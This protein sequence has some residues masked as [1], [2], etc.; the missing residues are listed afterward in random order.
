MKFLEGW[1]ISLTPT[2]QF[3]CWSRSQY[4]SRKFYHFSIVVPIARILQDWWRFVLSICS[5]VWGL[6][7]ETCGTIA[8]FVYTVKTNAYSAAWCCE[9][10]TSVLG[11]PL[12]TSRAKPFSDFAFDCTSKPTWNSFVSRLVSCAN[13]MHDKYHCNTAYECTM[14]HIHT[15][16]HLRPTASHAVQNKETLQ[17]VTLLRWS[18]HTLDN[19]FAILRSVL[20]MT[21]CPETI[22]HG[23]WM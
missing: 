16:L 12:A 10:V 6:V 23:I 17:A 22:T 5:R 8:V 9:R 4:W 1:N 13:R 7:S 2:I 18:S 11:V 20:V 19:L 21:C 14:M 3:W 15:N